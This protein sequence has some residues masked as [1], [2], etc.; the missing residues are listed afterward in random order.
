MDSKKWGGGDI[1]RITIIATSHIRALI[2][3]P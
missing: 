1:S 2:N 3:Y